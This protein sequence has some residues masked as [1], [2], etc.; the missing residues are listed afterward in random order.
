MSYPPRLL[1]MLCSEALCS[2]L[3][4]LSSRLAPQCA[5]VSCC[6]WNKMSGDDFCFHPVCFFTT[7]QAIASLGWKNPVFVIN[8]VW[9]TTWC[10]L[11]QVCSKCQEQKAA[12]EFHRDCNKPDG[13]RGRCRACEAAAGQA[14]RMARVKAEA[15]AAAPA[16]LCSRCRL[17][18]P[19]VSHSAMRRQ[20][21]TL[22]LRISQSRTPH[23]PQPHATLEP[24][25]LALYP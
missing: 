21:N 23:V 25:H 7:G 10:P 13:L 5:C 18:K 12:S 14:R 8:Q 16:K 15:P 20:G 11:S 4:I 17:E 24:E 9:I 22:S 1:C 19:G 3:C 6:C 2:C